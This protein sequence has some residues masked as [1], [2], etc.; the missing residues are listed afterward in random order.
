MSSLKELSVKCVSIFST[1]LYYLPESLESLKFEDVIHSPDHISPDNINAISLGEHLLIL[2]R[3]LP[4]LANL[5]MMIE[6]KALSDK[7]EPFLK[8]KGETEAHEYSLQSLA[9]YAAPLRSLHNICAA[10]EICFTS[11]AMAIYSNLHTAL[12]LEHLRRKVVKAEE[13]KEVN[14]DKKAKRASV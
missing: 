13:A 11:P 4:K 8:G 12:H 7:L 9:Q 1:I 5:H 10:R 3:H 6:T 2:P 14:V